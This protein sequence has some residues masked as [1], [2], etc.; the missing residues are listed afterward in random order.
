MNSPDEIRDVIVARA[1]KLGLT[2]YAISKLCDRSPTPE[3]VKRYF[4]NESR[5]ST[6][7]VSKIC[8]ILELELR[9]KK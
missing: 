8:K 2:A 9:P 6:D 5:M 3:S 1:R 7:K 4:E